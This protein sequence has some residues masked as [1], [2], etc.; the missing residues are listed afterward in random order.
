[1][2]RRVTQAASLVIARVPAPTDAWGWV[3]LGCAVAGA[4]MMV[5]AATFAAG[6]DRTGAPPPEV[7]IDTSV[8]DQLGRDPYG[9]GGPAAPPAQLQRPSTPRAQTPAQPAA[10]GWKPPPY[11][12]VPQGGL[13]PPPGPGELEKRQAQI[14]AAL[15]AVPPAPAP[16]T[17]PTPA[18]APAPAPAKAPARSEPKAQSAAAKKPGSP[19]AAPAAMPATIAPLYQ[20]PPALSATL[21]MPPLPDSSAGS[22]LAPMTPP[23]SAPPLPPPANFTP[24]ASAA[25][26]PVP[27]AASAP[28]PATAPLGNMTVPAKTAAAPAP[29]SASRPPLAEPAQPF[30]PSG[31]SAARVNF[32]SGSSD[33]PENAKSALKSVA[34]QMNRDA[35][36]RV[37]LLAYAGPRE[38]TASQARRL[39]LFRALAVRSYLIEQGIRSTRMDVRAMGNKYDEEPADRVDVVIADR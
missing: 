23:P 12:S 2:R 24:P 29:Q 16:A 1:M 31:K 33:L 3:V 10:S 28:P 19:A 6:P 27:T 25:V 7:L 14:N 11:A 15:G 21:A 37:Q 13:L 30:A 17:K 20:P 26:K 18:A 36:M 8:L 32:L 5:S 35:E 39:S 22:A 4:V 38:D 9:R 34:D